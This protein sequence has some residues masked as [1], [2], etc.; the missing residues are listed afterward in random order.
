MI[1]NGCC[2]KMYTPRKLIAKAPEKKAGSPKEINDLP[3]IVF[4]G[5]FENQEVWLGSWGQHLRLGCWGVFSIWKP[6][7]MSLIPSLCSISFQQ[8]CSTMGVDWKTHSK[9]ASRF[10]ILKKPQTKEPRRIYLKNKND[11]FL[12]FSRN[13]DEKTGRHHPYSLENKHSETQKLVTCVD[14]APFPRGSPFSG[15]SRLFSGVVQLGKVYNKG[16]GFD[17]WVHVHSAWDFTHK[18]PFTIVFFQANSICSG[19]FHL[20]RNFKVRPF[21]R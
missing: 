10:H 8:C 14:V 16:R 5:V 9:T 2:R 19:N 18:T 13:K 12:W 4:G 1:N 3:T 7:E 6:P 11:Q 15:S 21:S 17:H 20:K